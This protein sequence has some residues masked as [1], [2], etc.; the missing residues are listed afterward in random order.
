MPWELLEMPAPVHSH[1]WLHGSDGLVSCHQGDP[2]HL[3]QCLKSEIHDVPWKPLHWWLYLHP[4]GPVGHALFGLSCGMLALSCEEWAA[5]QSGCRGNQWAHSKDAASKTVHLVEGHQLPLCSP[6]TTSHTLPKWRRLHQYP[7]LPWTC[8]H[9][10]G[11]S[12]IWLQSLWC[13]R[14]FKTAAGLREVCSDKDAVHQ[15]L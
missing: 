6:N 12:W 10:C 4:S 14:C 9:P 13:E 8:Q 11:R 1:V 15:V 2:L 7:G 5:A 3:W